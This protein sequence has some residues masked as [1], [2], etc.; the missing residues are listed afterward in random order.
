MKKLISLL[1]VLAM[2]LSLGACGEAEV[3]QE[4]VEEVVEAVEEAMPA[5]EELVAQAQELY[6]SG[7]YSQLFS[8]LGELKDSG[9]E[10]VN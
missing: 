10:L 9:A 7:D 1:L 5:V 6:N 2:A 3:T 8:A 4:Q